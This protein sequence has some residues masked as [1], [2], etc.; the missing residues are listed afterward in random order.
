MP[1]FNNG[2]T[3]PVYP[4]TTDRADR[5]TSIPGAIKSLENQVRV[6]KT[7]NTVDALRAQIQELESEYRLLGC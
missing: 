3:A 2:T 4:S 1:A 5:C 6:A 7:Y